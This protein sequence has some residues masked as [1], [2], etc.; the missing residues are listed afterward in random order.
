MPMVKGLTELADDIAA[1]KEALVEHGHDPATRRIGVNVPWIVT[2]TLAEAKQCTDSMM[3]YIRRQINLVTP[4]NT[5]DSRHATHRVLGQLAAGLP[6][7]EAVD[8]LRETRM[9]VMDDVAGSRQAFAD[10]VAAGATDVLCQ[11]RVGG[12]DHATVER[13]MRLF[14]D[15]VVA[16][17]H[18]RALLAEGVASDGT[19]RT[20]GASPAERRPPPGTRGFGGRSA[21]RAP[22][23]DLAWRAR[24]GAAIERLRRSGT[25]RVAPGGPG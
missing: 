25:A 21:S 4:P 18:G 11:F 2:P 14:T 19:R 7:D 17:D 1:Y 23:Y 24:P 20:P 5:W 13:S 12:T 6:A 10:I 22:G 16:L 3:W 15:E 8:V 9:V